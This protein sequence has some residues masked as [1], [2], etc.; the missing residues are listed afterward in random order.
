[1]M[2]LAAPWFSGLA[3]AISSASTRKVI[4]RTRT[5]M[6]KTATASC[7]RVLRR[8]VERARAAD[9]AVAAARDGAVHAGDPDPYR[10]PDSEAGD[11]EAGHDAGA[12]DDDQ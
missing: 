8:W 5:K 9:A 10:V 11:D 4:R 7:S 2:S 6:R 3:E 1:M 12:D